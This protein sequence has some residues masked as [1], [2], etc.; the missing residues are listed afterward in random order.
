MAAVLDWTTRARTAQGRL[1]RWALL[2]SLLLHLAVLLGLP[3][4]IEKQRETLFPGPLTAR[5]VEPPPPKPQPEPQKRTEPA[6]APAPAPKLARPAPVPA[7][8]VPVQPARSTPVL[9]TPAPAP[10]AAPAPAAAVEPAPAAQEPAA[11]AS[12][13]RGTAPAQPF[14]EAASI[15]QYRLALMDIARGLKRYP[16]LA[17]ENNW[18]GRVELRIVIGAGGA[19]AGVTVKSSAGHAVLDQAALDLL[20]RAHARTPFPAALRGREFNIEI[21]VIYGLS[22]G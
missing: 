14:D 2:V 13:A 19:L 10:S 9:T 5:L 3:D 7:K 4:F 11:P 22:D 15:G 17:Q 8:P 18:Q 1:L 12:E 16:R 6:P 20:R 21:P